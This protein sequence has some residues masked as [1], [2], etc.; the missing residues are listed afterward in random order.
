MKSFFMFTTNHIITVSI[1][2]L[3]AI[4]NFQLSPDTLGPD[5]NDVSEFCSNAVCKFYF[6][7]YIISSWEKYFRC[8]NHV[9]PMTNHHEAPILDA[10]KI[11][12][13]EKSKVNHQLESCQ[14][15]DF[16]LGIKNENK[17]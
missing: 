8:F 3:I 17:F 5:F 4:V 1:A 12:G 11:P 6:G 9:V 15:L 14:D 7:M 2:L 13:I 16:K 10:L